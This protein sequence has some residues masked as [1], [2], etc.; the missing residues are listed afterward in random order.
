MGNALFKRVRSLY[1]L[2]KTGK[3]DTDSMETSQNKIVKFLRMCWRYDVTTAAGR[4]L[5]SLK[6]ISVAMIAMFGLLFFV[7]EDVYNANENIQRANV[8]DENLQSSLQV[9]YLIHRLQIERGLTVMCVGADEREDVLILLNETRR[10]TDEALKATKWPFDKKAG[11]EFLRGVETFRDHLVE[12]RKEVGSCVHGSAEGEISFYTHPINLMLDWF[13]STLQET[14]RNP[15]FLD[16]IGYHRFLSGKDKIGIERA[17]GGS[18]FAMGFYG[19]VSQLLWYT[20]FSVLGQ[21]YIETSGKLM[22]DIKI[23]I[24]RHVNDSVVTEIGRK[25]E[26]IR[27]NKVNNASVVKG[28]E[29]FQLMTLYL[30]DLYNVQNETGKSLLKRLETEKQISRS[31]L[32]QRLSFLLFSLLMVPLFI[33]S[34]NRMVGTIQNYTFQ[35]AQTTL[36][37]KEEK[38]RSDKLLYQMFPHPVA[39]L[40]KNNQQIPAE[41]FSSVTVFFSDIVN[42]TEMC[43]A[44]AP[45]QVTAL[46]DAVYGLFDNRISH[47]D[48]YKVETIGDA[49]M[50]V[51]GLPHR[52]GIRHADQ[53]ARMALDLQSVVKALSLPEFS[54]PLAIR[55]G[56]HTGPCVAGVV[57][58]KMPRYCLF[59]DTVNTASRMQTTGEPQTIQITQNTKDVLERI[60]GFYMAFRCHMDVK[61]KGAMSTFWLRGLKDNFADT[62]P[63]GELPS[64]ALTVV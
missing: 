56:I 48:V 17:L 29:W 46:L 42:F 2:S 54:Q 3:R 55:I 9:A 14:S 36:R 34:V 52:N 60:G 5:Q 12:H 15:I 53:I 1:S 58:N 18:F 32:I 44:M 61:G 64:T 50:V 33:L 26:I 19:N 10:K 24:N 13:Y 49:Y 20:N 31:N 38:M 11:A 4:R 22:P 57:G 7:A 45:L 35:L 30:D 51:S 43:S 59:G 21:D 28:Q 23:A 6:I 37:L 25:R 16:M 63:A 27:A 39:E 8:M 41:F 47:Y 62:S 40:L